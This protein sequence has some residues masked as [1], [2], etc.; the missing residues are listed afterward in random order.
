MKLELK[1]NV[2]VEKYIIIADIARYSKRED[3]T[4]VLK[5]AQENDDRVSA[6]LICTKLLGNK[7]ETV[8]EKIIQ[9]CSDLRLLDVNGYLT[10]KGRKALEKGSIPIPERGVY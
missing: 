1:R 2:K 4:A 8:G 7:P 3:I 6:D 5:L 10:D 9:R